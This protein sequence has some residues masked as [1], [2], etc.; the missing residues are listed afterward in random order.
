MNQPDKITVSATVPGQHSWAGWPS[1]WYSL[2]NRA[3]PLERGWRVRRRMSR[4]R[5]APPC[6]P[7]RPRSA[8]PTAQSQLPRCAAHLSASPGVSR[9]WAR[10]SCKRCWCGCQQRALQHECPRQ[11]LNYSEL[12]NLIKLPPSL[13][14][15]FN[16][17]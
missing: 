11:E 16:F 10:L 2:Q 12:H 4:V 9:R 1:A 7:R 17:L 5:A 3:G 15:M 14:R 8:D 6:P 13:K